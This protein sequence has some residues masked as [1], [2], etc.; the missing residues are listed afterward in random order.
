MNPAL[1]PLALFI[2]L[3]LYISGCASAPSKPFAPSDQPAPA[4]LTSLRI[5][6]A[7]ASPMIGQSDQITITGLDQKGHNIPIAVTLAYYS[8]NT[9]VATVSSA[10]LIQALAAGSS[11]ITASAPGLP[12]ATVTLTVVPEAPALKNITISPITATVQ[13]G[14]MQAYTAQGYDQ[15]GNP[16]AENF[17]YTSQ[18]TAILH[19]SVL[20]ALSVGTATIFASAGGVNSPSATLTIV[21]VPPTLQSINLSASQT[22]FNIGG[23]AT[24][25]AAGVDQYGNPF[26]ITPTFNVSGTAVT[27]TGNTVTG[28]S[29]GSASITASSGGM[30]SN[31][32]SFSVALDTQT[33]TFPN[34]RAQAALTSE[35]LTASASSGLPVAYSSSTPT[36]CSVSGS[37]VYLLIAGTCTLTATQSG[38]AGYGAAS[39][40]AS[41]SVGLVSQTI[42]VSAVPNAVA[43]SSFTFTGMATSGLPVKLASLTPSVCSTTKALTTG[44]CTIQAIQDGNHIYAAAPAVSG[45]FTVLLAP[46]TIT[47]PAPTPG[48][49]FT[50]SATSDSGLPVSFM[51]ETP[52]ICS[53]TGTLVTELSSGDCTIE[54]DQAGNNVYADASP[55]TQTITIGQVMT[56][57]SVTPANTTVDP[58][59]SATFSAT[60]YDQFNH[61][62]LTNPTFAWATD[63]TAVANITSTGLATGAVL[64][65]T[66]TANISVSALGV[67]SAPAQMTVNG[68]VLTT[69]T[70]SPDGQTISAPSGA[71]QYSVTELDQSGLPMSS[72][73]SCV[74]TSSDT[75]A[76]SIDINGL[77]T[78]QN[79]TPQVLTTTFS[80]LCGGLSTNSVT[81]TVNPQVR[82]A[83]TLV[84]TPNPTSVMQSQY[85]SVTIT[86]Y[87]EYGQIFSTPQ[88]DIDSFDGTV[89]SASALN[90]AEG[91]QILITGLAITSRPTTVRV[92][93]DTDDSVS[94]SF[95]VDVTACLP[96]VCYSPALTT[97]SVKGESTNVEYQGT[98]TFTAQAFDQKGGG[99]ATTFTWASSNTGVLTVDA[100]GNA[101]AVG[102]GT[103]SITAASGSVTGTSAMITVVPV[104]PAPISIATTFPTMAVTRQLA[105]PAPI[106]QN[107]TS[108][109]AQVILIKGTGFVSGAVVS[110]GSDATPANTTFKSST[111]LLVTVPATDLNVSSDT[112]VTIFVTNP[113]Q[114][115]ATTQ[116]VSN[117]V[118]F[119]ITTQG[120]VSITF[121][122]GYQSAYDNGIPL[123][124][125]RG[126]KVT[127]YVITGTYSGL[128]RADGYPFG[129]N[130]S[131]CPTA[132]N[133]LPLS[134]TQLSPT[135]GCLVG[136][137]QSGFMSWSE[138]Q[139][140]SATAGVEIGAHT[141]SHNPVSVL[142]PADQVGEIQ[143]AK[144]DLDAA[145]STVT[146]RTMA[147]PYGDYGCL[148]QNTTST[149]CANVAGNGSGSTAPQV[150]SLVVAAGFKGARSSDNGF[151]GDTSGNPSANLPIYLASFAGDS[152][153]GDAETAAQLEA[154]VNT[155][156]TKHAW[157]IFLFHR[158]D[159]PCSVQ[160]GPYNNP[161]TVQCSGTQVPNAISI[162]SVALQ[163]FASYLTSNNILTVTIS[164]G[165]AIEGLNAQ[166]Q[167][168]VFPTE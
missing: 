127:A 7:S 130:N 9:T 43:L 101:T 152:T 114:P 1:K 47:F 93:I 79:A 102:P 81:L 59:S 73:V 155:A 8:S 78:S 167:P 105:V 136:V 20:Q 10:G 5:A 18:G 28:A 117:S 111:Q 115:G 118:S 35:D 154:I 166:H 36:I 25:T 123:F 38:N 107:P 153:A 88:I 44:T 83:A 54:A 164:E 3:V 134:S 6:L 66:A 65:T 53:V 86:A 67:T 56:T 133:P 126:L 160:A 19:G 42:T 32:I 100:N 85:T 55:V 4:V 131:N 91:N 64:P 34:P 120:M 29:Q 72:F 108:S 149:T 27:V 125:S 41:F 22:S 70:L 109:R 106:T 51:S 163:D 52:T 104:V 95:T 50:V 14:Q 11:T 137:G 37:T 158:V 112:T 146:A 110:F 113:L 26:S 139:S 165:L 129:W 31:S 148:T 49:T 84:A 40:T 30:T 142:S 89:I 58:G 12:P 94:T 77:A 60:G 138:V 157:L 23:T 13:V 74:Y 75:A 21:Q 90:S 80:A 144:T 2:T 24:L 124:T 162:D 168:F 87:D 16:I 141:R 121:D 68:Q 92:H 62:M 96:V 97:I 135:Y 99:Y 132:S 69:V 147:Y 98:Q 150:G 33:V 45:T 57:I 103:A 116:A 82:F 48:E 63:N 71:L 61:P 119:L 76:A 145:L 17:T 156:V 161:A 140:L 128:T 151:E 39:A 122:D 15:Y 143:G 46:Q 159:D